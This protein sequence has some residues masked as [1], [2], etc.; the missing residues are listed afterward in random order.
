MKIVIFLTT[1][2]AAVESLQYK[3]GNTYKYTYENEV[4]LNDKRREE[5]EGAFSDVGLKLG[6]QLGLS[7]VWEKEKSQLVKVEFHDVKAFSVSGRSDEQN[8]FSPAPDTIMS[9]QPVFF[10][11][12][13]GKVVNFFVSASETSS[14]ANLKKGIVGIFQVQE[15]EGSV[16]ET[17]P[18]G[19]CEVSYLYQNKGSQIVK[20][21]NLESCRQE[22][23]WIEMTH[24]E[25]ILELSIP[26]ETSASYTLS[27]DGTIQSAVAVETHTTHI[28]LRKTISTYVS[29]SQTLAF[30]NSETGGDT[31]TGDSAESAALSQGDYLKQSLQLIP[32]DQQCGD[33]CQSASDVVEAYR[34]GLASD[35]LAQADSSMAFLELLKAFRS[36][37]KQALMDVLTH[38]ANQ[39]VIPQIL[40]VLASTQTGASW[41]AA[42]E[43]LDF[44]SEEMAETLERFL[45]VTAFNSHPMESQVEKLMAIVQEGEVG[46]EDVQISLALTVGALI[47]T[48]C[49]NPEVCNGQVVQDALA[50]FGDILTAEEESVRK[51]ALYAL[52]NA[53]QPSSL[54]AIVELARSE[55]NQDVIE[56]AVDCMD[57]FDE[58]LFTKDV[59]KL[60]NNFYHQNHRRYSNVIRAGAVFLLLTKNPS[61]QDVLNIA[62]SLPHLETFE[63][64]KFISSK[65]ETLSQADSPAGEVIR[66][67]LVS[68]QA[69]NYGNI[70][71]GGFSKS[72]RNVLA[73]TGDA[74]VFYELDLQMTGSG[75]L[76]KSHFDVDLD[77]VNDTLKLLSVNLYSTGLE[78]FFGEDTGDQGNVAA[79][80]SVK[81]MGIQLRPLSFLAGGGNIM[82]MA[83]NLGSA[84]TAVS[85]LHGNVLLHDHSE[86]LMLQSGVTVNVEVQGC[87]SVDLGGDLDFSLWERTFTTTVFNK[88]AMS[89]R[90]STSVDV[91]PLKTGLNYGADAMGVVNFV[92]SVKFASLPPQFCLQMIQEPLQYRHFVNK[93]ERSEKYDSEFSAD[94]S[95]FTYVEDTSFKLFD[96]NSPACREMFGQAAAEEN[97]GWW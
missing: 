47:K 48:L 33:E 9:L 36:S 61:R 85:P 3:Q 96:E 7:V 53:A 82:S 74:S 95:S 6:A 72:Y 70:I 80:V 52:R 45:V 54:S 58:E 8:V 19:E 44:S 10:E 91:S 46:S 43:V 97:S 81:L 39:E 12:N 62:L 63:L 88:G 83:W 49:E 21:K 32:I 40:D 56:T 11:W 25:K 29:S 1:I 20:V 78:S 75:L 30:V 2:L 24:P 13:A 35:L 50:V 14:S 92:T 55:Q 65:L 93:F 15:K 26:G 94:L 22:N 67:V 17:D 18:S 23:P 27:E 42:M 90:G 41:E 73:D 69:V 38:D 5:T 86:K 4:R 79:G 77:A 76:R 68:T 87:A 51:L 34:D 71:T 37:G 28:N 66:E 89:I 16:V 31:L 64:S 57:V 59:K 60:L 84:D